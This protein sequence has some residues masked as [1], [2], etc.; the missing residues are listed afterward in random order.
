MMPVHLR[1][2]SYEEEYPKR[3]PKN[4]GLNR[5]RLS[6]TEGC[7]V[8]YG[9]HGRRLTKRSWTTM[10]TNDA[11]SFSTLLLPVGAPCHQEN[12]DSLTFRRAQG[13]MRIRA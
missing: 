9:G 1:Y 7:A 12:C 6:E 10:L 11:R 8:A 4:E 2:S 5:F 3:R 13:R